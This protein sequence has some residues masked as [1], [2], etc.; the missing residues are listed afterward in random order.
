MYKLMRNIAFII[1]LLGSINVLAQPTG[2]KK[3]DDVN[4]FKAAVAKNHKSINDITADFKQIKHLS[5]LADKIQSKG[6]FYFKKEDKVRI[7]YTNPY[8]YLVVMNGTKMLVKDEQKTNKINAGNSK[9]MQSVNRIMVDCMRGTVL[10]N[11]DFKV[12]AYYNAKQYMLTMVPTTSDM[13]KLFQQIDVHMNKTSLDVE[14]LV[15]KEQ[16]GDYTEMEFFN[17]SHNTSLNEALFKVK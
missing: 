14:Q 9:M 12:T 15:M 10:D 7:E 17:T 13:K 16:G 4:T 6:K 8:S 1:F 2:F 11:P 5:L 3:L